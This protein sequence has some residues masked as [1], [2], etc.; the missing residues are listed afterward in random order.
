MKK[1]I[2]PIILAACGLTFTACNNSGGSSKPATLES[3]EISG[4]YKTDYYVNDELDFTGMV[5]TATYS[6]NKT[7]EISPYQCQEDYDF[8]VASESSLVTLTYTEKGVSASDGFYVTVTEKTQEVHDITLSVTV[9]GIETYEGKHQKIYVNGSMIPA[10]SAGQWG[11]LALTQDSEDAN[12]WS[13]VVPSVTLGNYYQYAYYYGGE[14]VS[15]V[16]WANGKCNELAA[17][18]N[19]T[20]ETAEGTY[21]YESEASFNVPEGGVDVTFTFKVNPVVQAT[22]DG[23]QVN[24]NEANYLW[25]WNSLDNGTVL[26]DTNTDGTRQ[27]ELTATF[28]EGV[29][30]FQIKFIL[31]SSN[32]A[33]AASD[34]DNYCWGAYESGVFVPWT[35]SLNLDLEDTNIVGG[36]YNHP[37]CVF[38]SE[39]E[40]IPVGESYEVDFNLTLGENSD[41]TWMGLNVGDGPYTSN[42]SWDSNLTQEGNTWTVHKSY[43]SDVISINFC[44]CGGKW[45]SES[46]KYGD[47]YVAA[48]GWF[49]YTVTFASLGEVVIDM[50]AGD[51]TA[52]GLTVGTVVSYSNCEVSVMTA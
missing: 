35:A 7:K 23:E 37:S 3:I 18:E 20:L 47:A 10:E 29:A 15:D 1:F 25:C 9:S 49:I 43:G 50:S 12:V 17:D 36:V 26:F 30:T 34:W 32:T 39:P 24:V 5:I 31:S 6:N 22:A 8:S 40:V 2:L 52:S 46:D 16:D 44:F 48:E 27:R 11:T 33:P 14:T 42:T 19:L 28:Y 41:V 13:V 51:I 4:E 45:V 21:L 38:E